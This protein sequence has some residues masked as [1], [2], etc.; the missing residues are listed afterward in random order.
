MS[1]EILNNQEHK[2]TTIQSKY[3]AESWITMTYLQQA[4]KRYWYRQYLHINIT[5]QII[6][7]KDQISEIV[8]LAYI[9]CH[10]LGMTTQ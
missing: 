9:Q 5:S 4:Q 6:V 2:W 8:T 7:P 1:Y 10:D 3:E